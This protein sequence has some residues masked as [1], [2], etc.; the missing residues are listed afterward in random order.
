MWKFQSPFRIFTLVSRV[1]P[2]CFA[3]PLVHSNL[4]SPIVDNLEAASDNFYPEYLSA[5]DKNSTIS[6][7]LDSKIPGSHKPHN[8]EY[9]SPLNPLYKKVKRTKEQHVENVLK[10]LDNAF[11]IIRMLKNAGF[12]SLDIL[13]MTCITELLSEF[14]QS[15]VDSIQK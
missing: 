4:Q 15:N 12:S 7:D 11:E 5:F 1:S 9:M 3:I 6:L 14:F 2:I 8:N 10:S 13:H